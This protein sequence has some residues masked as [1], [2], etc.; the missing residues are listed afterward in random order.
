MTNKELI[1]A[2]SHL[3]VETGSLACTIGGHR[4]FE[5]AGK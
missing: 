4:F 3:K 5:E 2:L 1:E